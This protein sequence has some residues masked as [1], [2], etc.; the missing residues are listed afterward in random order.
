[1]RA[2]S[3]LQGDLS[4]IMVG[5]SDSS[6][7]TTGVSD[8]AEELGQYSIE[9]RVVRGMN[10]KMVRKVVNDNGRIAGSLTLL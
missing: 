10:V 6:Q 1:M 3:I 7:A 5:A 9:Q 4:C 2:A 8:L